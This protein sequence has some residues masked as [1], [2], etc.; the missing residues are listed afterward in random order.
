[1]V[2]EKLDSHRQ[3]NETGPLSQAIQ[4]INSNWVRLECK[5][6]NHTTHRRKQRV[7]SLTLILAMIFLYLTPKMKAKKGKI[8]DWDYIRLKSSCTAKETITK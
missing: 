3:K 2:L 4:K 6:Q 5:T 8:S 7:S 1:M